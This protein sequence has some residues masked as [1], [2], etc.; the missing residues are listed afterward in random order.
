MNV[1]GVI[2]ARAA[3]SRFPGKPLALLR[4]RPLIE[5]VWLR[6][7]AATALDRLLVAT[8]D[9]AIA[10]AVRGFGG[11]ALVTSG[12]HASG[13]DRV[14]EAAATVGVGASD[15]VV[16]IQGD[17]PLIDPRS[18]AAAVDVLRPEAGARAGA[19]MG[20]GLV[21][22][23]LPGVATLAHV[24]TH[25][26]AFASPEVVKVVTDL[27]GEALYFSRAPIGPGPAPS[28]PDTGF[29][30]HVGL[31]VYRADVLERLCRLAPTPLERAERLEQLRA[32]E[33]G[34]RI[35]VVV[36][37][38]ASRGVDTPADLQALERDWETLT[39]NFPPDP[40]GILE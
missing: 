38:H 9:A 7:R 34:I 11:E 26:E 40:R 14:A 22:S 5:H 2:P 29:L 37:P 30:R 1:L 10:E 33:H 17:E 35:R 28:A 23:R 32:L 20:E 16:N 3:A 18:I 36:T 8:D 4:G 39:R 13:T 19:P 15:L 27:K 12:D 25:P 21:P 6:A 24:E 31:Y